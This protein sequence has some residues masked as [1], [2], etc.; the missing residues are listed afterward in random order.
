MGRPGECTDD[1]CG[2]LFSI[3]RGEVHHGFE[4]LDTGIGVDINAVLVRCA[5]N[6]WVRGGYVW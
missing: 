1:E 3:R 4:D 2:K 6:G 5:G